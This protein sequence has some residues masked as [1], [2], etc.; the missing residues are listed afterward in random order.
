MKEILEEYWYL[1]E[2][3]ATVLSLNGYPES[4]YECYISTSPDGKGGYKLASVQRW[5]GPEG[6]NGFIEQAIGKRIVELHNAAV[7]REKDEAYATWKRS[8]QWNTHNLQ[9]WPK[10]VPRKKPDGTK[11]T[12]EEAMQIKAQQEAENEGDR[13]VP[14][15]QSVQ[16][17]SGPVKERKTKT[18]TMSATNL[19]T[20]NGESQ[21]NQ[22]PPDF[23][24]PQ[25]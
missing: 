11:Y 1:I 18:P 16:A 20:G 4:H 2:R 22:V 25:E 10:G 24:P 8:Q 9:R 14:Q 19:Y 6:Y 13:T 23:L 3:Q 17:E 7:D 15:G 12:Y 5:G 21:I